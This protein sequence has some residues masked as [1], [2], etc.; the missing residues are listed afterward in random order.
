M[1]VL[2][3]SF[4]YRNVIMPSGSSAHGSGDKSGAGVEAELNGCIKEVGQSHF[5]TTLH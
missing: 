2:D 3:S 1:Q 5:W 4:V